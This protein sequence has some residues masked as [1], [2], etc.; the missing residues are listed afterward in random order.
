M[1]FESEAAFE[2][3]LIEELTQKRVGRDGTQK[4]HRR[5][6]AS[7]LGGHPFCQQQRHRPSQ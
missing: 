4:P 7:K 5:G 1:A 2:K 3:A 6:S